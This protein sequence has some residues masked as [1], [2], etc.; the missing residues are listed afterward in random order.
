MR[1]QASFHLLSS[2]CNPC[3]IHSAQRRSNTG[4]VMAR[5]KVRV[6]VRVGVRVLALNP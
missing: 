2:A 3:A 1:L 4:R 5:V 6:T